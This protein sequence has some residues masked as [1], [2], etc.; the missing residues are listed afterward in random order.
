DRGMQVIVVNPTRIYGP[1]LRGQ[2]NSVTHMIE[3]FMKGKWHFIPGNGNSQ[4]NYVYVEDVINGHLLAMQKGRSG[5][6]YILGGDNVTYNE[7]FD[8]LK[9]I[10][11][12]NPQLYRVPVNILL[13]WSHS[14]VILARITGKKPMIVPAFVKKLTKNWSLS[15]DK[16]KYELDYRPSNLEDGISNT[17]QWLQP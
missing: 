12:L 7:F 14:Q 10:T 15:S 13:V 2:S 9:D 4:G 5:E 1:G 3:L 6:R 16:A 11:G 8:L 17:L